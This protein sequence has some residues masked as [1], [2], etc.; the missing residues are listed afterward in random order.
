MSTHPANTASLQDTAA[1]LQLKCRR[2][3][4]VTNSLFNDP[5]VYNF[6]FL[7]LQEPP[8]NSHTNLP[9]SHKGW[10]LIVHQPSDTA[11]KL[12]P[13]SCIY[14]NTRTNPTIQ[15]IHSNSRDL[16]A[17]TVQTRGFEI[18]LINVYNQP[19]TFFGFEAMD[20][21]LSSFS[22]NIL[23]LPTIIVTDSN[24]HSPDWNPATYTNHD[25]D[26]D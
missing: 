11:E 25:A 20:A 17:C 26:A 8:V 12:R 22:T 18:L 5:H 24:L 13:R 21:L 19:S 6:L 9:S 1:V 10:H 7:A 14:V 16:A 2:S 3:H 4:N 15:P 23:L